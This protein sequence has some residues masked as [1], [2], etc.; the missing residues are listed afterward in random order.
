MS[1]NHFKIGNKPSVKSCEEWGHFSS[2]PRKQ[3][4]PNYI[5]RDNMGWKK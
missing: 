1:G 4:E 5:E 2:K 3:I